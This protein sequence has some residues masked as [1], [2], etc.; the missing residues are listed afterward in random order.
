[1]V[2][3]LGEKRF[4]SPLESERV[5][6]SDMTARMAQALAGVG[7][8]FHVGVF[9]EGDVRA[10]F[11][12]GLRYIVVDL[13]AQLSWELAEETFWDF[14]AQFLS[15]CPGLACKALRRCSLLQD[16]SARS[17]HD[18]KVYERAFRGC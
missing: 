7:M 15:F 1:V 5:L 14:W 8:H 6:V 13:I 10:D 12:F 16:E 2:L 17:L 4:D 9:L 11:G 18:W 3:E